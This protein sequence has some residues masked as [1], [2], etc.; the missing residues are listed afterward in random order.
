M[1]PCTVSLLQAEQIKTPTEGAVVGVY[2]DQVRPCDAQDDRG[3]GMP[4]Q[5]HAPPSICLDLHYLVTVLAGNADTSHRLLGWVISVLNDTPVIMASALNAFSATGPVFRD[6]E[7]VELVWQPLSLS[8]PY[9]AW[10][11]PA[12]RPAPSVSF[13]ARAVRIDSRAPS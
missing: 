12:Q 10:P 6:D 13:V 7:R 1:P 9:I 5:P 11:A 8:D 4:G 2:L 3:L